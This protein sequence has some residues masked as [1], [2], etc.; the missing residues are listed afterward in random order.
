MAGL[1][2][3]HSALPLF[4]AVYI[5][6]SARHKTSSGLS[7]ADSPRAIPMLGET[8]TSCPSASK[9]SFKRSRMRSATRRASSVPDGASSSTA[10]SSPKIRPTVSPGLTLVRIR[11]ATP[12]STVFP[13]S[14][15]KESLTILK[16]FRSKRSTA[17]GPS[18]RLVWARAWLRRSRNRARLG[19]SVKESWN[20]WYLS[21]FSRA[22]RSVTSRIMQHEASPSL[23]GTTLALTSTSSSE[24]SLWRYRRSPINSLFSSLRR[25]TFWSQCFPGLRQ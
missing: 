2:T 21:C 6:R 11:S 22:L 12:T 10:N 5:A 16:R 14:W 4:L 19:R 25:C 13:A 24:P 23:K 8:S 1:Y 15:P 9:G 7:C 20:A 17:T 3:S 18:S